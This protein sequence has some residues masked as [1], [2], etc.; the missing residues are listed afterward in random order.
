MKTHK[1]NQLYFV[2]LMIVSMAAWG[3]SWVS[4]KVIANDA[5]PQVLVFLRY[6]IT[7]IAFFP[8]L[9]ARKESFKLT[10]HELRTI[11]GG[12]LFMA[13]YSHCFF[14]GL[15]TGLPGAGGVLLTTL[16]PLFTYII[17]AILFRKLPHRREVTGLIL[18]FTGGIFLLKLWSFQFEEIV[19][20]GNLFFLAGAILWSF[21]ALFSHEAQKTKSVFLYSFYVNVISSLMMLPFIQLNELITTIK[22]GSPLFWGNLLYLSLIATTFATTA[23]FL[24]TKKLGAS[25]GSTFIFLVPVFAMLFSWLILGEQPQWNTVVGGAMTIFA[26]FTIHKKR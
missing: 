16:N 9:I 17:T 13:L 20:S 24:S 2:I 23:Y 21:V 18:G 7:A 4:A 8:M 19:K 22:K 6:F 10:R 5:S 26:I 1:N 12:A 25:K 14:G 15:K 3:G 11:C